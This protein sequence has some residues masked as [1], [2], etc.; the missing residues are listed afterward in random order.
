L[1]WELYCVN[2]NIDG[3]ILHKQKIL[4]NSADFVELRD[5]MLQAER[6]FRE[7]FAEREKEY[8]LYRAEKEKSAM[9]ALAKEDAAWASL[10]QSGRARQYL[11]GDVVP[12]S[13]D[14]CFVT[15]TERQHLREQ[16]Q[17][18]CIDWRTESYGPVC[19]QFSTNYRSLGFVDTPTI[20]NTCSVRA[21]LNIECNGRS[22]Y[23]AG[24]VTFE[25]GQTLDFY[26]IG[27]VA[28]E[29]RA[30]CKITEYTR[31]SSMK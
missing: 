15:G 6:G 1:Y 14:S 11:A 5:R 17:G 22:I 3:N 30:K 10:K 16:V 12:S 26:L 21:P 20:T 7:R 4:P 8:A 29:D 13:A 2:A 27:G 24:Y 19:D 31:R 18:E 9:D 23:R 28:P 25:P